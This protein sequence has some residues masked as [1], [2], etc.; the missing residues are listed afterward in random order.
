MIS[1]LGHVYTC[2]IAAPPTSVT[3]AVRL[4]E[5][6]PEK[7]KRT[8]NNPVLAGSVVACPAAFVHDADDA[9]GYQESSEAYSPPGVA[10][11]PPFT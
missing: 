11:R 2:V 4:F 7:V 3:T 1:V 8:L 10:T 9:A 5:G 6:A